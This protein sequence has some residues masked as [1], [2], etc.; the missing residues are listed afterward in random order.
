MRPDPS[1]LER[2]D[3]GEFA[4]GQF[5]VDY[6]HRPDP[7]SLRRL[8]VE[9]AQKAMADAG[10]D[11][12][13]LWKNENVRYLTA[14]RPQIIA[15]KSSFLNGCLLLADREPIALLSGGEA[16]RAR[17]VMPWL[18][19][20]HVVPIMEA[21]GLIRGA[22]EATIAPLL[23]R[24]G[25]ARGRLGLD[26]AAYAQ[27]QALGQALP[28]L[29]LTDG[30][31]VMQQARRIKVPA[32]VALMQ[33][34]CAI[35][36]AVTETAMATVSPG[37]R[38]TDVVAEAMHTLYRLGGEMPHVITP[39]V[40]SGEHMSPPNRIASDKVIREGDLVFIDIGAMWGGYFGDLGRTVICGEPNR[41]QQEIYSAVHAC[42]HAGAE[43]M[44]PGRTNEDVAAAVRSTAGEH[45]LGENFISLFIG[46]GVGIG[47]NEP[48]Y[49]GENLPGAETV[50]LE[51][52]MTF[53]LEPLIW[54]PGIRG[55]GG[56]RL[57][58]TLL[59]TAQGSRALTR[60]RFDRALLL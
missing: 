5:R 7:E 33:E 10:L 55:G 57:E 48:P 36:E 19:E 3:L 24:H 37:V 49:V 6:E 47:A 27:V 9:R 21:P 53:A 45:G 1:R 60:T 28:G 42:L 32:E 23:E 56:V 54:V 59:V 22:V 26:A 52:G 12:L 16:E 58:D 14:L 15:G 51:E 40:A 38:E 34:A 41:R 8:R 17:V 35:A 43:A 11:A 30:D 39:F 46:H 4:H 31:V 29:E 50:V 25:V 2:S 44:A 18:E 13:L 20:I